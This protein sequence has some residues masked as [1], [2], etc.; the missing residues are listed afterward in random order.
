MYVNR[1]ENM[2]VN[3]MINKTR[4]KSYLLDQ[5]PDAHE[6]HD[7]RNTIIIFKEGMRNML[8]DVLKK[9]NFSEDAAVLAKAAT[10]IRKDICNYQGFSFT[11]SFPPH[12]QED[13]LPTS[14]KSLISMILRGLSLKDADQHDS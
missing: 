8:R 9:T 6:Q 10:I 1:L 4:L 5:F 7:D 12:C 14:L 13:S 3:K 2:G 11:G